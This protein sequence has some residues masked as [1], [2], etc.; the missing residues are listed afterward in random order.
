MFYLEISLSLE[1]KDT[2]LL[3]IIYHVVFLDQFILLDK[4]CI[5][6]HYSPR[7]SSKERFFLIYTILLVIYSFL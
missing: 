1:Y 6:L 4:L 5:P 2:N 7:Y 3:A